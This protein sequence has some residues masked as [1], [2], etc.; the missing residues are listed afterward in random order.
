MTTTGLLRRGLYLEYLT[1]GW[2]VV[3][4]VIVVSAAI[5]ARSVA[6]AGFGLASRA[7]TGGSK[8]KPPKEN[9]VTRDPGRLRESWPQSRASQDQQAAGAGAPPA[10]FLR[11]CGRQVQMAYCSSK[12]QGMGPRQ[13]WIA[14]GLGVLGYG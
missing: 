6:L 13:L 12:E 3:G 1:L 2:N 8:P 10:V 11:C 7:P 9:S 14:V 4:V 5:A